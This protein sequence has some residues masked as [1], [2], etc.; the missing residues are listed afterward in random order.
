MNTLFTDSEDGYNDEFS[1][2][3]FV[4]NPSRYITGQGKLQY[5]SVEPDYDALW[6]KMYIR[7]KRVIEPCKFCGSGNAITNGNCVQCGA[8][9]A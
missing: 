9:I 4:T 5:S 8:P 1:T 7:A 6:E 3:S 2:G